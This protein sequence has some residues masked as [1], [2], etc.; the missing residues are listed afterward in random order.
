MKKIAQL[1]FTLFFVI[2]APSLEA[3]SS[4]LSPTRLKRNEIF[5]AATK[6]SVEKFMNY[7]NN[8]KRFKY[9]V[10]DRK[11]ENDPIKAPVYDAFGLHLLTILALHN[12]DPRYM[13]IGVRIFEAC[14]LSVD[15]PEK[16]GDMT[17]LHYALDKGHD[18]VALT[19]LKAGANPFL[20]VANPRLFMDNNP[21]CSF[22]VILFAD[23][24]GKA[25]SLR[26]WLNS[27]R[28]RLAELFTATPRYALWHKLLSSYNLLPLYEQIENE[29]GETTSKIEKILTTIYA[30]D[31][32]CALLA[33][34]FWLKDEDLKK[35]LP[36][37]PAAIRC[38]T[39]LNSE[40]KLAQA[41][42]LYRKQ[43]ALPQF[44][45]QHSARKLSSNPSSSIVH[46]LTHR[47]L[48]Q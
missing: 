2:N 42:E 10:L 26:P 43:V 41:K 27:N 18:Q 14:E 13:E 17:A 46:L 20:S 30:Q 19:L 22:E 6:D 15:T 28:K 35:I 37:L 1:V 23:R 3:S 44:A 34:V 31:D 25:S 8:L 47:A 29:Y 5:V 21:R 48:F 38:K 32:V 45:A 39:L 24:L 12:P 36:P 9:L 16:T 7:S 4:Y 40:K 33:L 11:S